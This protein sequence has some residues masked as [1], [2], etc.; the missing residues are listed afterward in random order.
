MNKQRCYGC[1]NIKTSHPVCEHC[2]YDENQKNAPHQLPAGTVLKDH[3]LIGKVL[4]QGGFGITYLGWDMNLDTPVAIKEYFPKGYVNR[5]CTYAYD[6]TSMGGS[7]YDFF[8]NSKERFLREAQVL[9][10]FTDIPEIVRV[11]NFFEA[12]GTAYIIMEYVRGIDLRQHTRNQGGKLSV[13]E[14][15]SILRP[16]MAALSIVHQEGL[17]HRDISPDNIMMISPQKA[18][19]LDFGAV[20]D[21]IDADAEKELTKSTEAILKPGFAPLEQYQK[22]GALGPWT[23][24]Y[25]LCASIY[26]CLTGTVPPDAPTRI[27][28]DIHP[29]WRGIPGLSDE[30]ILAMENAMQIRAKD[31]TP[32]VEELYAQLFGVELQG[33]SSTVK[34]RKV[35][36]SGKPPKNNGTNL[37]AVV[38]IVICLIAGAIA[39]PFL[40][41]P[42]APDSGSL[43]ADPSA[44]QTQPAESITETKPAETH[45]IS[46]TEPPVTEPS[47]TD[48]TNPPATEAETTAPTEPIFV[49]E[50]ANTWLYPENAWKTNTLKRFNI[51]SSVNDP[52]THSAFGSKI[53]RK[54]VK[55][56]TFLDHIADAPAEAWDVSQAQNHS[57]LAWAVPNGEYYDL[58][59]GGIGGI[60]G[61]T[62]CPDL[63]AYYVNVETITFGNAFHTENLPVTAGMFYE[64]NSLTSID[65]RNFDTSQTSDMSNMFYGCRSLQ[66]LDVSG[67]VT[68]KVHSMK[69]MFY[70][71]NS[72]KKLDVSNFNTRT[73]LNMEGMFYG[74]HSVEELDVSNFNTSRVIN[75]TGMFAYCSSLKN[76]DV[77]KLDTSTAYNM[78]WMFAGCSGLESLDVSN[79]RTVSTMSMSYMFADCSSLKSLDLS[80]FKTENAN[81]ME[82]MFSG[83]SSLTDLN[84][85]ALSTRNTLSLRE[86]FNKCSSL[87]TLDLSH[88]STEKTTDMSYM[89]SECSS[90]R[91]LD[92]SS[93]AT[94]YVTNMENMFYM[95]SN[96]QT[97][98][99]SN[100]ITNQ[101]KDMSQMFYGCTNL[102]LFDFNNFSTKQVTDSVQFMNDKA[103]AN[104]KYWE[105]LFTH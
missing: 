89:F 61:T 45:A 43:S 69:N 13:E 21:V 74:C 48:P 76:L 39:I 34:R 33:G 105:E 10:K 65:L 12:N 42:P 68:T 103:I 101:C 73:V 40:W 44:T 83:C 96:L 28:E 9:A 6:V 77:S 7:H 47:K 15:F 35:N 78:D 5:D 46:L 100:F 16:I 92:V 54:Q 56:I 24:I 86:M 2:G 82:G 70:N 38:V 53:Q 91:E 20:R 59:I 49:E 37:I 71:C 25:A 31:R 62:A 84:I 17:V 95:C 55:T 79:F 60:N 19:L 32:S 41:S 23:D 81:H 67:F 66:K 90:L 63:F 64:C 99:V 87:T 93:L 72:I 30:Q 8:M 98:D 97:L 75:M 57:V 102:I 29:N 11:L 1:M 14:T 88:F 52:S 22:R 80:S 51:P 58:Y 26:Y 4:G 104:G 36:R 94:N 85:K 50:S 27:T 3:Y 18:K